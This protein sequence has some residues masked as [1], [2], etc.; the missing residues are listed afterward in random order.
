MAARIAGIDRQR[1][2]EAVAAGF[3]PCA[4][5]TLKG[6]SRLFD[7]DDLIG[8]FIF[9]RLT[10]HPI[11]LAPSSAGP[12]AC[13]LKDR[14]R[15]NPDTNRV[16]LVRG[17]FGTTHVAVG[18]RDPEHTNLGH[19]SDLILYELSFDLTNVRAILSHRIE[20]ELS[21]FGEEDDE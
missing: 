20:D 21:T 6:A 7:E 14:A 8:L 12:L 16:R 4:P 17:A 5:A 10:E 2:N 1:F 19:N 18:I 11:N 3:Y 9:G 13:E 15:S